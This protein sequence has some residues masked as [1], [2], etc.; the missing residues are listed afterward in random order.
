MLPDLSLRISK[1]QAAMRQ[2]SLDAMLVA[3]NANIFYLSGTFFRGYIWVPAEGKPVFF[4][5]RPNNIPEGENIFH[6]RKPEQIP[7]LLTEH[8]IPLPEVFGLELDSLTYST[9]ERLKKLFP[10]ARLGNASPA[11]SK[12]RLTKTPLE[13][14]MMREDG[15]HQVAAYRRIQHC[16]RTDMTDL[17][18]QIEIERMLRL[19]G[20][21]GTLRVAGNL[22]E[23][24][25]GNVISGDNADYPSPY[26]FSMG[27]KGMSPAMPGG[28]DGTT[29]RMGTTVMVDMNGCFNGYQTDLT[30]V[31]QLGDIPELA[32]KAHEC[33][34]HILRTLE[35]MAVPGVSCSELY[36]EAVRIARE[37][38]LE[39]Y[40]M[41]HRQKAAFIG[42]GVGIELNEAPVV[43][44]RSKTLLEENMTIALEPKFVIPHVG[45][46]GVE[47][48][49]I[50]TPAGLENITPF[51]EQLVSLI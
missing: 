16:Y 11:L 39:E 9:V 18:F 27:G 22:M 25:M 32:V 34:R 46:V 44:P 42:H 30:R 37:E 36:E 5:I 38:G 49:Y 17:E 4:V 3:S 48:T 45:A 43:T 21:L 24:N 50:V 8:A 41:G 10:E 2:N 12:A 6:I 35:K 19:E 29:M 7:N 20:S 51:P 47:N 13:L 26:D 1:I 33:S 40:F 14:Q 23:I 15:A 31:W 28:A